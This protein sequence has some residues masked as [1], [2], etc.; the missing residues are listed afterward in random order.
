[1]KPLW[2]MSGFLLGLFAASQGALAEIRMQN[3][4]DPDAPKWAEEEAVLPAL[5]QDGQLRKIYVSEVTSHDFFV[6][7]ASL[8][9]GKDGVVRYTLVV[10][11]RGGAV[12]VTHEGIRCETREYKIYASGRHDSTWGKSRSPTWRPIENKPMNRQHASLSRDYFC[13][14]GVIINSPDE[15]REA[16]RLGKHPQAI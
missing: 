3:W 11:T 9:V 10:K 4:E 6:D 8:Q 13:P 5:P 2:V 12:N 7:A 14:G 1:M 15:G 16:L